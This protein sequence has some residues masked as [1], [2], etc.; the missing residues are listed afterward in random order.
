[1]ES[2]NDGGVEEQSIEMNGTK[3]LRDESAQ[4]HDGGLEEEDKEISIPK[5]E[6]N[7]MAAEDLAE[8]PLAMNEN[9]AKVP[10]NME[11]MVAGE[12]TEGAAEKESA[13][14][15][16]KAPVVINV[17][18][19][20]ST[21][22]L[23]SMANEDANKTNVMMEKVVDEGVGVVAARDTTN[24]DG[25]FR[26]NQDMKRILEE[27]AIRATDQLMREAMEEDMKK[28]VDAS[29]ESVAPNSGL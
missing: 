24:D 3:N 28:A 19:A 16:D 29:Q 25:E 12:V 14:D 13:A 27:E 8:S 10:M 17:L 1:M 4:D 18:I 6:M 11:S 7:K 15:F 26:M 9:N 22:E 20:N 5:K 23:E 21:A 2:A